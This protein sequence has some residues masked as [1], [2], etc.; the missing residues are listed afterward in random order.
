[1]NG[2]KPLVFTTELKGHPHWSFI[3]CGHSHTGEYDALNF[4]SLISFHKYIQISLLSDYHRFASG[5]SFEF[6]D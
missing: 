2:N 5:I 4:H 6:K 1:M 3:A